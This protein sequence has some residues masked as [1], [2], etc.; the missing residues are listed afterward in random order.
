MQFFFYGNVTSWIYFFL[1]SSF[2]FSF[3][4]TSCSDTSQTS[5]STLDP[6]ALED[7]HFL[8]FIC[9]RTC[10]FGR[11]ANNNWHDLS[12]ELRTNSQ[13]RCFRITSF[14]GTG[15]LREDNQFAL[16]LFQTLYIG[17]KTFSSFVLTSVINTY[18]N[19]GCIFLW[20]ASCFK[21]FQSN[22]LPI[23]TLV[24]YSYVGHR[25]TGRTE[26]ATGL[27]AMAKA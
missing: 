8:L 13:F 24:L 15:F 10:L 1:H 6:H 3:L 20:D 4:L 18:S 16:V 12:L 7:I 14:G 22:P 9:N 11:F 2:I 23:R 21:F 26:P 27:G 17:L 19:G 25:T 5:V